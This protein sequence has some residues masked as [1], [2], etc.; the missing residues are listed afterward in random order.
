MNSQRCA[1]L[2]LLLSLLLGGCTP[3]TYTRKHSTAPAFGPIIVGMS[4]EEVEK[5]LGKPLTTVPI[6]EFSYTNLYGYEQE[7]GVTETRSLDFLNII[8]F[9]LGDYI[10][11]PMDRYS[12]TRHLV[13]I[14]YVVAEGLN[15]EKDRVAKISTDVVGEPFGLA[16]IGD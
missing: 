6:D 15:R 11:T 9:G 7:F 5:Y 14:T 13:A 16:R 10:V 2:L 1:T 3:G 4:L 12:G 8:T